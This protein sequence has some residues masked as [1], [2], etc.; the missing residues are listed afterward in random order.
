MEFEEG[1]LLLGNF[2]VPLNPRVD[3]S[4]GTTS[5]PAG[6]RKCVLRTLH[7]LQLVDAWCTLHEGER[8]YTF[9]S[10]PHQLYSRIDLLLA[11]VLDVSIGH[12]NLV[13]SCS[14]YAPSLPV[15]LNLLPEVT[16]A[17]V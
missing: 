7:S 12:I 3:M 16:L 5:V 6:A 4:S 15:R 11:S 17:F 8:D 1:K 14:S 9:F 10:N 13:G 2:N